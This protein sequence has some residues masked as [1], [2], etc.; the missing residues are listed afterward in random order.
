VPRLDEH[1]HA[2]F[3]PDADADCMNLAADIDLD[4]AILVTAVDA[5]LL[6]GAG[7]A[8]EP[9]HDDS[10]SVTQEFMGR[11]LACGGSSSEAPLKE[12]RGA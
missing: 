3:A 1:L 9:S 2:P 6:L 10:S 12:R 4:P 11:G 7:V 5:P 8:K